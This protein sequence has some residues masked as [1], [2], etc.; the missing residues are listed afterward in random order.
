MIAQ[1]KAENLKYSWYV[2]SV[3]M[4]AYVSSFID[5]QILSL[6]VTPMKRDLELSDFQ[7][8]LLMGLS[9]ALFYTFLGIPVGWLADKKTG[10]TSS[11]M[12]LVS[13]V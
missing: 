1:E 6:L 5:R 4:L 9:F 10:E 8:S 12:E 13:G 7:M 11:F 3:L 2:V